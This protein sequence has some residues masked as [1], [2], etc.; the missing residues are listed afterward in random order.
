MLTQEDASRF[1]RCSSMTLS[2]FGQSPQHGP[3]HP[4]GCGCLGLAVE[5]RSVRAWTNRPKG[6]L[7]KVRYQALR[8]GLLMRHWRCVPALAVGAFLG[9]GGIASAA[10]I[11][12]KALPPPVPLFV[13]TGFYG[14]ANVGYSWGG[15]PQRRALIRAPSPVPPMRPVS[16]I[17][18][19]KQVSKADT[20]I[21]RARRPI[22]LPAW[23]RAMTFRQNARPRPLFPISQRRTSLPPRA[24]THC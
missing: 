3:A 10:D 6:N 2:A 16:G 21:S 24:S 17:G 18:V 7:V 11:P 15:V 1:I 19:G 12:F 9:A 5:K 4:R 23:K 14:G 13:W 22:S 20:A 8:G